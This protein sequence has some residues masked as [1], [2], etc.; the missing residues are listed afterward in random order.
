MEIII[1]TLFVQN[2][3]NPFNPATQIEY[4]LP[5]ATRVLLEVFNMLGE[6][7]A[8]LVNEEKEAGSYKVEFSG[9]GLT[10]GMYIYSIKTNENS[11]VRKMILLK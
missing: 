11:A 3:P 4:A 7:A 6:K 1:L 8:T 10:S 2:F 5:K 9:K